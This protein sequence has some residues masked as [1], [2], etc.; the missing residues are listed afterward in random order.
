MI[1]TEASAAKF[2]PDRRYRYL[3][4]RRA[5]FGDSKAM[6]TMLNPSDADEE[7]DDPTIRRSVGFAGAW[8]CGW[9]LVTN[10]SPHRATNPKDLLAQGLEPE[11]VRAFNLRTIP[12]T[13]AVSDLVVV[14]WGNHGEAE[15]RAESV[16]DVLLAEGRRIHCLGTTKRGHPLHPLYVPAATKL[17]PFPR[18]AAKRSK[19]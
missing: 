6:L 4:S 2:S 15:G 17:A 14:A 5:G 10:L 9:L 16:L 1:A 18:P 3:L 13:S 12:E 19:E 8:G 7:R 11:D